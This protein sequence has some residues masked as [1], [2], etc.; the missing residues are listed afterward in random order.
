MEPEELSRKAVVMR[1]MKHGIAKGAVDNFVK[2]LSGPISEAITSKL[3]PDSPALK[4]LQPAV[5]AILAFIIIM[6]TAEAISYMAPMIGSA[7]PSLGG[8][9]LAEKSGKLVHF[10]RN[11]AGERIGEQM[12]GAAISVFPLVMEQFSAITSADLDMV[13][14][15]DVPGEKLVEA[16]QTVPVQKTAKAK[17][18]AMKNVEVPEPAHVLRV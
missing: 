17:A 8:E 1:G 4:I 15:L 7:A 3:A 9:N 18:R 12:I 6:G 2:M 16:P 14:G 5:E 13:N 10:M 11:Y